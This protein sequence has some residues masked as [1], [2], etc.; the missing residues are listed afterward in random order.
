[1]IKLE[2]VNK[3][4]KHGLKYNSNAIIIDITKGIFK[5]LNPY[6][7][8]GDI[9]VSFTPNL[10][11]MSLASMWQALKVYEKEG[12]NLSIL[13]ES[14]VNKVCRDNNLGE[15]K[16]YNRGAYGHVIYDEMEAR[17]Q[18]YVPTYKWILDY[19]ANDLINFIR[20][21]SEKKEV[22]ILDKYIGSDIFNVNQPI[23][24]AYLIKAYA[25][26]L[27]PYEDVFEI[28]RECSYYMVGR[29]EYESCRDIR[30]PKQIPKQNNELSRQ[31]DIEFDIN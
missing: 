4:E 23:S 6:Y 25:E 14:H 1:M 3:K 28:R 16:G 30:V 27:Y 26:G 10:F 12:V 17:K 31:L 7:R 11:A 20:T 24:N 22:V 18:I 19:K 21:Q 5:K 9:P 13:K 8:Y 15:L 2:M 29:R